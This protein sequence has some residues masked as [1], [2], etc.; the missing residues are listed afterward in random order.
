M[1]LSGAF[2]FALGHL[3]ALLFD[4][5][6]VGLFGASS[7]AL[8]RLWL[9]LRARSWALGMQGCPA[10]VQGPTKTPIP[11]PP[12][13]SQTPY[14]IQLTARPPSP[15]LV[16]PSATPRPMTPMA[17]QRGPVKQAP[18][19]AEVTPA[20]TLFSQT[21]THARTHACVRMMAKKML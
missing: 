19:D 3:W 16:T 8:G 20:H 13:P 5:R 11:P 15:F 2:A 9:A 4:P 14:Y 18:G 6:P 10:E 21:H 7:F 17:M 12:L 1:D